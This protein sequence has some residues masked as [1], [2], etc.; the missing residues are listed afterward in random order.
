MNCDLNSPQFFVRGNKISHATDI[1]RTFAFLQKKRRRI[2][3]F[4]DI[5]VETFIHLSIF[6]TY[7]WL[8]VQIMYFFQARV[9]L[10][11]E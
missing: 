8:S 11:S 4:F 2:K 1:E 3:L 5:V 6:S 7:N 9:G 10:L